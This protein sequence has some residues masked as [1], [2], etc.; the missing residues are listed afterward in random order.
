MG[1]GGD[2]SSN[3]APDTLGEVVRPEGFWKETVAGN[4]RGRL[5][6]KARDVQHLDPWVVGVD[7]ARECYAIHPGHPNL[8]YQ[9]LNSTGQALQ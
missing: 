5:G 1:E 6:R 7:L 8:G 3:Q 4:V 9:Q 2:C